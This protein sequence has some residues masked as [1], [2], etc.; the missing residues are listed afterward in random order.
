MHYR[1]N[2]KQS[3]KEYQTKIMVDQIINGRY[4]TKSPHSTTLHRHSHF[5]IVWISNG[6]GEHLVEQNKYSYS[7]GSIFLLAPHFMHQIEYNDNVDGFVVSFS[8]TFLNRLQ[9]KS[10]LLFYNPKHCMITVP[11]EEQKILNSEFELLHHHF[12]KSDMAEKSIILQNYL[13]II[14]TKINSYRYRQQN[15][16]T[17]IEDSKQLL[18]ERFI[19]LVRDNFR[20]NKN[21]DFYLNKLALS[22]RKLNNVITITT[23]LPPAKFIELYALNEAARMLQFSNYSIK[24]VADLAGYMD[25]SYFTKAFKRHFNKTPLEY[26]N[27]SQKL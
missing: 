10:T 8:D 14:L 9:Y 25:N 22:Q 12:R 4:D 27:R 23:G 15:Q 24:E 2:Y 3:I 26:R 13:H 6:K 18:A 7:D 19:L 20:D 21:L 5:Q 17:T 16:N 11:S 1:D